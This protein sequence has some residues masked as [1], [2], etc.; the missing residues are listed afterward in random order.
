MHKQEA[1]ESYRTALKQ[2]QKEFK[3]RQALGLNPYPEVLDDLLADTTTDSSIYIGL[4]EIPTERIVGVRS[5][6]RV[7]AFS[8][9]FLPLLGQDSEFAVKWISLCSDHLEDGIRDPIECFEYL[10]NFYVQEGNKRV[11][12][13]KWNEAP[14]SPELSAGSCLP[15]PRSHGSKPTW[16]SWNFTS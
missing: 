2:A 4:V 13:L 5:S 6:G 15:L 12:V 8:A 1:T 11:S 7:S 14:G 3:E 9:G 10:G 16:N